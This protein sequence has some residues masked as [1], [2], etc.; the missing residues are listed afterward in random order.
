MDIY[1]YF[2]NLDI[3]Y[4]KH[5]HKPVFTVEETE[6]IYNSLPGLKTKNLFLRDKKRQFFLFSTLANKR[7]DLKE[8]KE[9]LDVKKLSFGNADDLIDLIKTTPGSVSIFA[10][11]NDSKNKVQGVVDN[12]LMTGEEVNFHPPNN[13]SATLTVSGEDFKKFL[14]KLP[15]KILYLDLI[16]K[17]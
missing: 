2:R 12:D 9:K 3:S 1:R 16:G 5:D 11:I 6:E 14:D 10:L 13:N 8:L 15:R 4:V 7:I 17:K